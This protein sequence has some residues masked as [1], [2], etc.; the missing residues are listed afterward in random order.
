M[1]RP[2]T[3]RYRGVQLAGVASY[4]ALGPPGPR[5]V[6]QWVFETT[7]AT[8]AER[9]AQ[10]FGGEPAAERDGVVVLTETARLSIVLT[11]LVMNILPAD[12]DRLHQTLESPYV[13]VY[14]CLAAAPELGQFEFAVATWAFL[15]RTHGDLPIAIGRPAELRIDYDSAHQPLLLPAPDHEHTR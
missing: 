12:F 9:I 5:R 3:A 1:R 11:G 15:A 8:T 7:S 2:S 4:T 14:F 13:G 10:L 6:P